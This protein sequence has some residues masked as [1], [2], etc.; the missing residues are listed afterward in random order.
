MEHML[1][2]VDTEEEWIDI[3][4]NSKYYDVRLFAFGIL[5]SDDAFQRVIDESGDEDIVAK[6]QE[7]INVEESI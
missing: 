6:A 5:E 1:D 2:Y 3:V 7:K 4:V